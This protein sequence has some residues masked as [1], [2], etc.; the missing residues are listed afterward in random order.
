VTPTRRDATRRVTPDLIEF[1]TR[2]AHRLRVEY[3]R[4]LWRALWVSLTAIMRRR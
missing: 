4:N 3:C 1:Y 2:R